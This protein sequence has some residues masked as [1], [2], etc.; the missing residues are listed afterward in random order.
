LNEKYKFRITDKVEETETDSTKE[1]SYLSGDKFE[2]LR[3]DFYAI[4]F[5]GF[6][7]SNIEERKEI[8]IKDKTTAFLDPQDPLKKRDRVV[9][10]KENARN[11][12][13]CIF[14]FII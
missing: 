9:S 3:E 6:I 1:N 13:N 11:F 2:S 14:I 4:T 5:M 12:M 7:Y 10:S 8:E